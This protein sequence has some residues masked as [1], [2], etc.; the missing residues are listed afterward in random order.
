[1][2]VALDARHL[3]AELMDDPG[4]DPAV[5]DS[6]LVGLARIN[7]WSRAAAKLAAPILELARNTSGRPLRILDVACGGGDVPIRLH[8]A[9]TA[10]G[11][12]IEIE[13][14]D[15]HPVAVAH[16]TR[17][18]EQCGVGIRFFLHDILSDPLPEGYDVVTSSLFL[19]HLS[20]DEAV[21]ALRRMAAA[22]QRVIV[23][24]LVRSRFT[25]LQVWIA[26]H[27]LTR[28]RVN[29][30]DGPVSVRAAFQPHEAAAIAARAGLVDVVVAR[31][32]PCR[33]LLTGRA[34]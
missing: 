1:M 21:V 18:A 22:G 29:W 3:T 20:D 13:G 8:K 27:T 7:A 11:L 12:S 25:L 6:A 9:A 33:F 30:Y 23:S 15:N 32:R 14:C 34:G 10:A 5:L 16:A 31:C 28:S 26:C 4:I 2:P 19:H 24:D 17:A